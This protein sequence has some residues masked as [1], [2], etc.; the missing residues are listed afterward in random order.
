[1]A[2]LAFRS[3]AVAIRAKVMAPCRASSR[4]RDHGNSCWFIVTAAI[5]LQV[6][7]PLPVAAFPPYKS[8]DAGTAD[9]Y[10]LEMRLGFIQLARDGDETTSI[11]PLLRANFGLPGKLELISEFEYH[12]K[13]HRFNDG[14]LGFK[15]VPVVAGPWSFGLE[16]LALIPVRAADDD[17]GVESQ[18]LATWHKPGLLVH[19]NAGGFHDPRAAATENGWRA[20]LLTESTTSTSRLGIELFAKQKDGEGVDIRLGAGLIKDIAGMQLRSAIH[21]GVTNQAP[22]IVFNF[23]IAKKFPLQR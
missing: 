22:D 23:W 11:S 17:V 5:I 18:F 14:A 6:V 2:T 15:W 19:L 21:I 9:P 16:T 10:V 13:E 4:L 20:S 3:D 1:M 8:T 12:P 7:N